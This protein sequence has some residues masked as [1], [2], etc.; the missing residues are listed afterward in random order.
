[1]KWNGENW[2]SA[3]KPEWPLDRQR[4][5]AEE[6]L[7]VRAELHGVRRDREVAVGVDARV[8][9]VD[10]VDLDPLRRRERQRRRVELRVEAADRDDEVGVVAVRE[11][12][13]HLAF[14]A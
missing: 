12:Q 1:M 14:D 3:S 7:G 11:Q 9:L 4:R 13:A 8:R 10:D 2:I 5:E 6:E